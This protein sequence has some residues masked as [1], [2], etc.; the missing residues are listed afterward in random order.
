MTESHEP[1]FRKVVDIQTVSTRSLPGSRIEL[2]EEFRASPPPRQALFDFDGT[3]SLIREGW[4]E[5]MIPLFVEHLEGTGTA[6]TRESLS[7]ICRE[8]VM[9]LTGK[10][11][12]YQMIR[13]SEE[14]QK[15]GGTP[16]EPLAYKEEYHRRLM[17]RIASRRDALRN[18][19]CSP[20]D[21]LVP[22]SLRVLEQLKQRGVELYLASGTDEPYV[23]EEVELLGLGPF[24]GERVFG[25]KQDYRMFSKAQVIRRILETHSRDGSALA[26][27]GDGYVEIQN[28]REAGGVAVAVAS[29][30]TH[31]SGRPDAWKR[32]RLIA[33]GA[34]IVVP[35]FQET[36]RLLAFLFDGRE[37]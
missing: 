36:D 26:G 18:G 10:Q 19:E 7:Q 1:N 9:E 20:D 22:G 37:E 13:L 29:D 17:D 6:E 3:L 23:R 31:R 16:L 12:I 27:F 11:T 32:E 2:I 14:I 21:W 28:V 33:A 35:D 24:F 8:F 15:R 25:A 34:N 30:E 5:V 4:P